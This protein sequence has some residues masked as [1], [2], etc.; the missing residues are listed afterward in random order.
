MSSHAY[1]LFGLRLHSEIALPELSPAPDGAPADVEIVRAPVPHPDG[2]PTV[3]G[4]SIGTQ[5]AIIAVRDIGRYRIADGARI[6]IDADPGA[7]ERNTRLF[8]LGSAMGA[9]LHQRR[10][11]PLHANAIDMGGYAIAV[12]GPSKAGKSTLAAAFLDRGYR[13]LSDDICVATRNGNGG[14]GAQPGALLQ[15]S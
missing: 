11:L 2:G 12:A 13:L 14:F 10:M 4:L 1:H 5:G 9:L 8:L 7:S 6:E 3:I 15:K